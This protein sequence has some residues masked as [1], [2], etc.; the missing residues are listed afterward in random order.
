MKQIAGGTRQS[1]TVRVLCG[2]PQGTVVE[3]LAV[4]LY[5]VV[6]LAPQ[7]RTQENR[8]QVR[9]HGKSVEKH[10]RWR[11][12]LSNEQKTTQPYK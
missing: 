12:H 10:F 8:M 9:I 6:S 11:E 3:R 5:W 4:S 1:Q 2:R 7:S